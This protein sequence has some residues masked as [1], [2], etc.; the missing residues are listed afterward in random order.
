[1]NAKQN[2]PEVS[3]SNDQA[4]AALSLEHSSRDPSDGTTKT[5]IVRVVLAVENS[6]ARFQMKAR[7]ER[8][9][10]EICSKNGFPSATLMV[11]PQESG[12]SDSTLQ[13]VERQLSDPASLVVLVGDWLVTGEHPL[14]LH[15]ALA[16]WLPAFRDR[17]L[18]LIAITCYPRRVADV[19]RVISHRASDDQIAEAMDLVLQRMDYICPPERKAE[20][21]SRN[22]TVRP[23][24]AGNATEFK[25]YFQ[26]RHRVY[27]VMGYLEADVES[28]SSR[29]EMN[30]ADLHALHIGAFYRVRYQQVL[31]GCARVVLS[32]GADQGLRHLC[33]QLASADPVISRRL[34]TADGLNLPIF[35]SHRGMNHIM[36]QVYRENQLCGELSR[37]VV[38]RDFR[39][40][41]IAKL[42][43]DS[44]VRR[45][46]QAGA[47]RLFLECLEAHAPLYQRFGFKRLDGMVGPVVNV[48]RTMIAMELNAP[49]MDASAGS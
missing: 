40:A 21:D 8:I 48:G 42:L 39:G 10:P 14:R 17:L 19:D 36:R 11:L 46:A 31:V 33:E 1:M 35:Q 20:L 5:R 32:S 23:L 30:E 43:V 22:L 15:P 44:G 47:R 37:V 29:L 24:R 16:R 2:C 18:A 3:V 28:A 25:E 13:A 12:S 26:M 49:Q 6:L 9:L 38:G 45:A 7:L 4:G 34:N 41:G 27:R